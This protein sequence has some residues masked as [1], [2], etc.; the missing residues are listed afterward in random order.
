MEN[1]K[2]KIDESI[3]YSFDEFNLIYGSAEKVT[4]R[5][6]ALNKFNHSIC[7]AIF[8]S[9]AFLWNWALTNPKYDYAGIFTVM[10]LSIIASIFTFYWIQQIKEYK[11]LN[12]AKFKVMNKMSKNLFFPNESSEIKIDS[13]EPFAKEWEELKY[14]SVLQDKKVFKIIALRSSNLEYFIP[15]AF[16]V[17]FVILSLLSLTAVILNFGGFI[18]SI[19]EILLI[20]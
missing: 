3:N 7:T 1:E 18:D 5:R 17:I 4:D 15:K 20:K 9:I 16:G 2:N 8:L 13:F 19:K 6:I 12:S 14:L 10:I 11:S